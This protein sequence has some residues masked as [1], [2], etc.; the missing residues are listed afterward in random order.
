MVVAGKHVVGYPDGADCSWPSSKKDSTKCYAVFASSIIPV[1]KLFANVPDV[2]D[3]VLRALLLLLPRNLSPEPVP[4]GGI[5]E[6]DP[7]TKQHRYIQDPTG[8]DIS[9]LTGVT[10]H[11]NKLYLGSLRNNYIGVYDLKE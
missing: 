4:Y 7:V 10:V 8:T 11:E 2:V 1:H 5:L 3:V 9:M 6:V